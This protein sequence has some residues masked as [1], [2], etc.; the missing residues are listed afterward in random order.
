MPSPYRREE[1]I[2][3]TATLVYLL[4]VLNHSGWEF[5]R[6]SERTAVFGITKI[7]MSVGLLCE[8]YDLLGHTEYQ[9]NIEP[10][11]SYST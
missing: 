5:R 10:V 6:K 7:V 9:S 3:D 1:L 2:A 4:S 11:K 8:A